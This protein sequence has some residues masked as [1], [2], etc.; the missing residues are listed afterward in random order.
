MRS[1]DSLPTVRVDSS[2]VE[3]TSLILPL[4]HG[5][6]G[7]D[8]GGSSRDDCLTQTQRPLRLA[9]EA[10]CLAARCIPL[11]CL[12]LGRPDASD[13]T[14]LLEDLILI[15]G[16]RVGQHP[17]VLIVLHPSPAQTSSV[18]DLEE[19][20]DHGLGDLLF[21]DSIVDLDERLAGLDWGRD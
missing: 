10:P 17:A 2:Y 8:R 7:E 4:E 9:A 13:E 19:L 14:C 12:P 15:Q 20:G 16:L 1:L 5:R 18:L 21:R 6:H 11:A 3:V